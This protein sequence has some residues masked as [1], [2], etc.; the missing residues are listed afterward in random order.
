[1]RPTVALLLSFLMVGI[2]VLLAVCSRAYYERAAVEHFQRQIETAEEDQVPQLL[3]RLCSLGAPG[4]RALVSN[5][6]S[7]RECVALSARW[8]LLEQLARWRNQTAP[9]AVRCQLVLAEALCESAPQFD[10]IGKQSAE[11]LAVR[12]LL[13]LPEADTAQ[14]QQ[15]IERC[16]RVLEAVGAADTAI[17]RQSLPNWDVAPPVG[18]SDVP[19]A[20]ST[21][22]RTEQTSPPSSFPSGGTTARVIGPGANPAELARLPGG[23]LTPP[24]GPTNLPNHQ[25]AADGSGGE[26]VFNG[27]QAGGTLTEGSSST[28]GPQRAA[29]GLDELL[30]PQRLPSTSQRPKAIPKTK[31][32][33][34]VEVGE[35]VHRLGDAGGD[36]DGA[37][38]EVPQSA[39]GGAPLRPISHADEAAS[40]SARQQSPRPNLNAA[41][42]D[43][44]EMEIARR[45][46]DPD[47]QVR[48][49]LVRVLPQLR[50]VDPTAWL[51]RL[52]EDGD[53]EV[54]LEAMTL[55]ATSG[56]PALLAKVRKLAWQDSNPRIRQLAEQLDRR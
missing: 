31:T 16:R 35:G 11:Q 23:G 32:E 10:A 7:S 38:Q 1:M 50:A 40:R 54:R 41:E 46:A 45:L 15:L 24:I 53:A 56:N 2:L 17:R 37:V 27:G 55:L 9:E 51:L 26:A 12:M 8:L 49:Q 21:Q 34:P 52:C 44:V 13:D 47:P 3:A 22:N 20:R 39:N 29:N 33:P 6:N 19:V 30:P 25:F 43:L 14:R 48:K 5:L 28:G 18:G 36:D 42:M 4:V